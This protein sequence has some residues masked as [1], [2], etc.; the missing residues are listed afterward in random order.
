MKKLL[1]AAAVLMLAG[2]AV[3]AGVF[4]YS[5]FDFS[6]FGTDDFE[7][8]TYTAQGQFTGV[9]IDAG[10]A[11]VEFKKSAGGNVTAECTES[12]KTEREIFIKGKTLYI[13]RKDTRT[14]ADRIGIST[15]TPK[16]TVYLPAEK[17]DSL[18]FRSSTGD[19][20]IP[21]G[22]S[23]D[24]IDIVTDTGDVRIESSPS[25]LDAPTHGTIDILT[26]TG[27]VAIKRVVAR[28]IKIVTDTGDVAVNTV[29]CTEGFTQTVDTGDTDIDNLTCNSFD[30]N[31]ATGDLMLNGVYVSGGMTVSRST[32]DVL[33]NKSDAHDI[34]ITTST[35]DVTGNLLSG[36]AFTAESD[37]GDVS[38]PKNAPGGNCGIKTSTGDIRIDIIRIDSSS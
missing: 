15:G 2:A 33:I 10:E 34:S 7:P 37:T 26:S 19:M 32:G 4:A 1:I 6:K 20:E 17:Y 23:F 29:S 35:G 12:V 36:K 11:D 27:D 38:V 28:K 8:K 21:D 25:A 30:S 14:W 16:M 31:G 3:I 24:K 5:G 9:D 18:A 13:T 22:F